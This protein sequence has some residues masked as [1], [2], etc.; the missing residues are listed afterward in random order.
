MR[1]KFT[2]L[3]ASLLFQ[4][5]VAPPQSKPYDANPFPFAMALPP[6]PS[7]LLPFL[8]GVLETRAFIVVLLRPLR[9]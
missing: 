4:M 5:S 2:P 8:I 1:R 3:D 7:H 6:F 9:A